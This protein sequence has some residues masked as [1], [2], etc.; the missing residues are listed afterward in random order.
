MSDQAVVLSK[1]NES[2]TFLN[3]PRAKFAKYHK[4]C[5]GDHGHALKQPSRKILLNEDYPN[6]Q[7]NVDSF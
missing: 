3:I 2:D 5:V 1:K 4:M 7:N 6:F